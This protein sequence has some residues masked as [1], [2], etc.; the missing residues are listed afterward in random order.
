MPEENASEFAHFK[1]GLEVFA[2]TSLRHYLV[3]LSEVPSPRAKEIN[4]PVWGTLAFSPA[5]VAVLDSPLLQRLRRIRQLGVVHLVFPGATHTRF[6]HS[7]GIVSRVAALIEALNRSSRQS[8]A[9]PEPIDAA[10]TQLMRMAALCHDIG[11]GFMS[12]VSEKAIDREPR[13]NALQREFNAK[14]RVENAHLSEMASF[15]LIRSSAFSEL[16]EAAWAIEMPPT[17]IRL[18]EFVSDVVVG[19]TVSD[20]IPLLHE[21]VSGPFDAD[22]LDYL[23]RDAYYCGVP[24]IVDIPRLVQK[25]RVAQ[26]TKENLPREIA[27]KV[28]GGANRIYSVTAV[29][30]SGASTLDELA[31]ARALLHDKVYRHKKVRSAEAMVASVLTTLAKLHPQ[32]ELL[33]IELHDEQF[34]DLDE[35]GIRKVAGLDADSDP[36]R[37]A[38]AA[39]LIERLRNRRLLVRAFSWSQTP[40]AIGSSS[41]QEQ[42]ER[43]HDLL[44]STRPC[45]YKH[46]TTDT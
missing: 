23:T 11:H 15:F 34:L 36:E 1:N 30:A 2:E 4:D 25:I 29:D 33:P 39:D 10:L 12:H 3:T 14:Y 38:T 8:H 44:L 27:D 41:E 20:D 42:T 7:L 40:T 26:T 19:R 16:L 17:A 31:L 43:L 6:E 9:A 5:E 45:K 22:K 46:V 18:A 13:I 35:A 21:L 24:Q 37:V 28:A 32:P